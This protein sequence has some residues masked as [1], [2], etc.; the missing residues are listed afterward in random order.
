MGRIW[1]EAYLKQS[2]AFETSRHDKWTLSMPT[3]LP[4]PAPEHPHHDKPFCTGRLGAAGSLFCPQVILAP[5]ASPLP[6]NFKG[7]TSKAH[8]SAHTG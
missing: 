5:Q 2:I 1:I 3:T 4:Q 7:R 8:M 6:Y